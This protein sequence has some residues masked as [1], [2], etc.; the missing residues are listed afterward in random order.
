MNL[1]HFRILAR[2]RFRQFF[3]QKNKGQVGKIF[4]VVYFWFLE[5]L[6]FFMLRKEGV[7]D[8]PPLLVAGVCLSA[9]FPDALFKLISC[10]TR[11]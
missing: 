10:M 8:F 2:L 5:A 4:L 9:I 7:T 11:Q 1:R 6:L 3:R